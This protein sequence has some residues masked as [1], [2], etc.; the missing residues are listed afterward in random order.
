VIV[1]PEEIAAFEKEH[2][3]HLGSVPEKFDILH[4]ASTLALKK[5]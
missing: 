3:A 5:K 1:S 4:C 2:A